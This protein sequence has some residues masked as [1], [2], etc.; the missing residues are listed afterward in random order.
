MICSA[1]IM[2]WLL[3]AISA[4][5][6]ES[7]SSSSRVA[8]APCSTENTPSRTSRFSRPIPNLPIMPATASRRSR[9]GRTACPPITAI[10]RCPS[11]SRCSAATD[12]PT[13]WLDST[14][15]TRICG[16]KSRSTTTTGT[17][18]ADS[19][20]IVGRWVSLTSSTIIPSARRWSSSSM[21]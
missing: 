7:R 15:L 10:R 21:L 4:V 11:S 8:A 14:R 1:P 5:G 6:G 17:W 9:V 20:W 12:M 2:I 16:G 18:S 19:A 13:R 3:P